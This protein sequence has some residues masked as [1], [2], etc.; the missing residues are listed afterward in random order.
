MGVVFSIMAFSFLIIVHE[1]G[2]LISAKMMG[3]TVERFSLGLG[4]PILK[5]HWKGTDYC[6]SPI[7][8]G[9]YVKMKG[10]DSSLLEGEDLK[11]TEEEKK[12]LENN[13][14]AT[15]SYSN[16][17]FLKKFFILVSGSSMN[18]LT[19]LIIFFVLSMFY[20]EIPLMNATVGNVI[21]DSAAEKAGIQEGDTFL[22]YYD[23]DGMQ[24]EIK[25]FNE[26]NIAKDK[27]FHDFIISRD[28]K[29]I[30]I[31]MYPKTII[32][33]LTEQEITMF[34]VEAETRNPTF[35]ESI[36]STGFLYKSS[37]SSIIQGFGMLFNNTTGLPLN[38]VVSGP[39]GIVN[40]TSKVADKATVQ[41]ISEPTAQD[42]DYLRDFFYIWALISVNLGLLNLFPLPPLDGGLVVVEALKPLIQRYKA[43][44]LTIKYISFAGILLLM[45]LMIFATGSD[46]TNL[47][48]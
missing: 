2:H 48:S 17:P 5:K 47:F 13:R 6:L 26:L 11:I 31:N 19:A 18:L 23:N 4:K 35:S 15:D 34:G 42:N 24:Y 25:T 33:D 21:K 38:K 10:D 41:A 32:D 45:G 3:V 16:K 44:R 28:G 8:F 46:L 7:P 9:G 14:F 29:Q 27:G 40:M 1:L 12:E 22:Y 20:I 39:I 43:I 30:E 37:V 36:Q